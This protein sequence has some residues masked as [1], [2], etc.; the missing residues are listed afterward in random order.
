MILRVYA[1]WNQSKRILYILLI[2]YVPQVMISFIF[3]GIFDNPN[4]YLFSMSQA[5][6]HASL[7]SHWDALSSRHSYSNWQTLFL[8]CLTQQ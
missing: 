4:K 5:E 2:T 6:L 7:Q 1:M 8:L 3:T